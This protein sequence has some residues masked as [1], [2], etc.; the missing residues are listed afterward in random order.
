MAYLPFISPNQTSFPS[1][2]G[3]FGSRTVRIGS[4]VST[5]I[6]RVNK[7]PEDRST[8]TPLVVSRWLQ[9]Y[10]SESYR[11][12]E[13]TYPAEPLFLCARSNEW[14]VSEME[15]RLTV[16]FLN[17]FLR[18][19]DMSAVKIR[20]LMH[21]G[22]MILIS[23]A[24]SIPYLAAMAVC[25]IVYHR[26]LNYFIVITCLSVFIVLLTPI[27]LLRKNRVAIYHYILVNFG[28]SHLSDTEKILREKLPLFQAI[29]LASVVVCLGSALSVGCFKYLSVDRES[30]N[31]LI[32][33]TL[34]LAAS[35]LTFFICQS[36]DRFFS[37]WSWLL[38]SVI[39]AK[40]LEPHLNPMSRDKALIAS[41][42]CS[43]LLKLSLPSL[44]KSIGFGRFVRFLNST[45]LR[46]GLSALLQRLR[47]RRQSQSLIQAAEEEKY[48]GF[49]ETEE[50]E[51]VDDDELQAL[52]SDL[53]LSEEESGAVPPAFELSP[54]ASL[55][56]FRRSFRS[57]SEVQTLGMVDEAPDASPEKPDAVTLS[58]VIVGPLPIDG[59][60]IWIPILTDEPHLCEMVQSACDILGACSGVES[61]LSI[62]TTYVIEVLIRT[63]S[64]SSSLRLSHWLT[65]ESTLETINVL[66][67]NQ[68][69]HLRSINVICKPVEADCM[70]QLHFGC[71]S[72][73]SEENNLG[74]YND[75]GDFLLDK[76]VELIRN[77]DGFE[78]VQVLRLGKECDCLCSGRLTILTS[79][80][81]DA[82]CN[83]GISPS[84]LIE[85]HRAI[86]NLL[87]ASRQV[88]PK[89]IPYIWQPPIRAI[90]AILFSLG[91]DLHKFEDEN[92]CI[93]MNLANHCIDVEI[94][95]D[96]VSTSYSGK[97]SL[98]KH[99]EWCAGL[100]AGVLQKPEYKCGLS[101]VLLA[102]ILGQYMNL[103]VEA[104]QQMKEEHNTDLG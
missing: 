75:H 32:K 54:S 64:S 28:K 63:T 85:S 62:E 41:I 81:E 37:Q 76:V 78:N 70:V 13:K 86:Q 30:R 52:A 58:I 14:R 5:E 60:T 17:A 26:G 84:H 67:Q 77:Q 23:S 94:T 102:V 29:Y 72:G 74:F 87:T 33:L 20:L 36:L 1:C 95:S 68:D 92:L 50:L 83:R 34:G 43:F 57:S 21:L 6:Y 49:F 3:L 4:E 39:L 82:L 19:N 31:T 97:S 98:K 27:M 46:L 53:G 96:L 99:H 8:I 22:V 42:L 24:A 71:D 79:I 11:S 90:N 18:M 91:Y 10:V 47:R 9:L 59:I 7:L 44:L 48:D 104:C 101:R 103:C 45:W 93:T 15:G 61:L 35:L 38:I 88:S 12:F 56:G 73:P 80:S 55:G 69:G 40:T 16:E 100:M 89:R 65:T 66:I 25:W 2:M 51:L